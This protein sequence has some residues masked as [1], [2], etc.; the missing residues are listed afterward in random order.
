MRSVG[1]SP[2]GQRTR[3]AGVAVA[4]PIV[5]SLDVPAARLASCRSATICA[6][7]LWMCVIGSAAMTLGNLG[8]EDGPSAAAKAEM[9]KLTKSI[10]KLTAEYDQKME[11][12]REKCAYDLFRI[13]D[14]ELK[15][16]NVTGAAATSKALGDL[17]KLLDDGTEKLEPPDSHLH[18]LSA[19]YGAPDHWVDATT[20]VQRY[21]RNDSWT[22][23]ANWD[24]TRRLADMA[25]P[26]PK[27]LIV[28]YMINGNKYH[29]VFREQRPF[30]I[31]M[32][33][34]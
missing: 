31:P 4:R 21:C 27:M 18:I 17:E 13:M 20:L 30:H 12:V 8:A 10:D 26:V 25:A 24:F 22:C 2:T 23:N 28:D 16:T 15:R 32:D 7:L 6:V 34:P 9:D 29:H 5:P 33:Q 1:D 11:E 3:S 14:I 19:I